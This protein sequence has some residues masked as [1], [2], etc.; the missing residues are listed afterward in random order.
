[1]SLLYGTFIKDLLPPLPHQRDAPYSLFE[2]SHII[3]STR[4]LKEVRSASATKDSNES[5]SLHDRHGMW[6]EVSMPKKS[7]FAGFDAPSDEYKWNRQQRSRVQHFQ[8]L[9]HVHEQAEHLL[10]CSEIECMK[11][12]TMRAFR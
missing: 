4:V 8:H 9:R 7:C 5:D 11:D 10:S 12:Q 1:M 2:S 6:N 3:K